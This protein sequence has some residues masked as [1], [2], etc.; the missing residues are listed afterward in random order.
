[1][2]ERAIY[3]CGADYWTGHEWSPK[4]RLGLVVNTPEEAAQQA[5][6][7]QQIAPRESVYLD[8]VTEAE[9]DEQFAADV[10]S[11]ALDRAFRAGVFGPT[12]ETRAR[13]L[14]AVWAEREQELRATALHAKETNQP[15]RYRDS[16]AAAEAVK[17][18]RLDLQFEFRLSQ[19][20]G[21]GPMTDAEAAEAV[22]QDMEAAE[23]LN[24]DSNYHSDP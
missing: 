10:T 11:G 18:C 3:R 13:H 7:I 8:L 5:D 20:L 21:Y 24:P 22:K 9:W 1:M 14:E 6:R 23:R 4:L 16:E 19:R 15:V 12:D 2:S 17:Q